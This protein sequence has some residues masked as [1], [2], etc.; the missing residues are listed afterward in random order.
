MVA[1][2][3][4]SILPSVI[5]G[6]MSG[7]AGA[8]V[9]YLIRKNPMKFLTVADRKRLPPL[10]SQEKM[11]EKAVAYVK[12]FT[13]DSSWTWYATE[14]DGKDTFFGLVQG[15]EEE[16]GYFSLAELQSARGPIG[17]HIERDLWFKPTPIGQLRRRQNPLLQTVM[18]MNPIPKVGVERTSARGGGYEIRVIPP[19]AW[20]PTG[21]IG[22]YKRKSDAMQRAQVILEQL[23]G[24]GK[25]VNPLQMSRFG[26]QV[27]KRPG[28]KRL[29]KSNPH[30]VLDS[31]DDSILAIERGH[32]IKTFNRAYAKA[33]MAARRLGRN[34]HVVA[35]PYVPP[36]FQRGVRVSKMFYHMGKYVSVTPEG[37]VVEM[38]QNPL[39]RSEQYDIE[40][41]AIQD[42]K[43]ARSAAG[44]GRPDLSA[45][46]RGAAARSRDIVY[47][48]G[49]QE[50]P[51]RGRYVRQRVASPRGFQRGSFRT[52]T[53]PSGHKV[54]IG[55]PHGTTKT[56]AQSILHPMRNSGKFTVG[57]GPTERRLTAAQAQ[58]LHA[59]PT[60]VRRK[61]TMPLAKFAE[62]VKKQRNP[63]LW[64][65]FMQKVEGYKKWTHGTM[66][67]SVTVEQ[68]EVP[69]VSGT[70]ITY[71][72]GKQAEALYTMPKGSKRTG[73]WR[74]PW[75]KQPSLRHDPQA[76]VLITKLT[77]GNKVTDFYHG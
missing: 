20:A 55:R 71:D 61:T 26:R 64:K 11:G 29:T 76:G 30:I 43:L 35:H 60:S 58:R 2:R 17:L 5:G 31:A 72:A 34:V 46:H 1:K 22:W 56:R 53:T 48:Y 51:S 41:G 50:N 40:D 23:L 68:V 37:R 73:A 66:P 63:Q 12:F 77:S 3:N 18:G 16:L 54:V 67:K 69:G 19:V 36:G 10:R 24:H 74:H 25:G 45:W 57:R 6:I 14:F 9:S 38:G 15:H 59:N 65:N 32:P 33:Q 70:W 28:Q 21:R 4:A 39:T 42:S 47:N 27:T 8:A 13:P 62:W 44:R 49:S 52:I 75:E 7:A